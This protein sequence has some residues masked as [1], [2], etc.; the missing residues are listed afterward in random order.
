MQGTRVRAL[1]QEDPTCCGASK[2]VCHNYWACA[3]EPVSH[4]YWAC[5]PQLL[6]PARSRAR[7]L[8]LLRPVRLEPMLCNEKPPQWEAH[9]LQRRVA[10]IREQQQLEKAP[11][12]KK[13]KTLFIWG[14]LL[15]T[16]HFTS[17]NILP[18]FSYCSLTWYGLL[19]SPWLF[20]RWAQIV[21][22][23]LSKSGP[24]VTWIKQK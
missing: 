8:Q 1:V 11:P 17:L 23:Y 19:A 7:V 5:T 15:S 24:D 9:A 20:S 3:L 16:S 22:M 6:K 12:P 13:K 2:P 10:P 18:S 14:P 4:N 21:S